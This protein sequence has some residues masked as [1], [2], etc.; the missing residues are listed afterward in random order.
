[1]SGSGENT[2]KNDEVLNTFKK[3]L[4][5][6][7]NHCRAIIQNYKENVTKLSRDEKKKLTHN[8]NGLK[9]YCTCYKASDSADMKIH[10]ETFQDF[11]DTHCKVILSQI[12]S[13]D[14]LKGIVIDKKID[15][16]ELYY[17]NNMSFNIFIPLTSIYKY[18]LYLQS[19]AKKI[20]EDGGTLINEESLKYPETILL[21]LYLLFLNLKLDGAQRKKIKNAVEN[22]QNELGI[23]SKTTSFDMSQITSMIGPIVDVAASALSGMAPPGSDGNAPSAEQLKHTVHNILGNTQTQTALND[24]FKNVNSKSSPADIMTTLTKTLTDPGIIQSINSNIE[25]DLATEDADKD[26]INT[27]VATASGDNASGE[28][29]D[30][31]SDDDIPIVE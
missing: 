9:R 16:I 23:G 13:G 4:R 25:R 31:D 27:D 15:T 14:W 3:D 21:D 26:A 10:L 18:G 30:G 12:E 7:L 6:L 8:S 24:T 29:I 1:M 17:D 19:E 11:F 5:F 2:N 20:E 22:L 28:D